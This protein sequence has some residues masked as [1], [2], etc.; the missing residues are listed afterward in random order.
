MPLFPD[1]KAFSASLSK[2]RFRLQLGINREGTQ[3]IWEARRRAELE[4]ANAEASFQRLLSEPKKYHG[5]VESLMVLITYTRRFSDTLTTLSA[6][7]NEFNVR[8]ELPGLET[9]AQQTEYTLSNLADAVGRGRLPQALP[10]L[11]ATLDAIHAHLKELYALRVAE[12]TANRGNTPTRK[13]ML[14]YALVSMLLDRIADQVTVMHLKLSELN[15]TAFGLSS[16][17]SALIGKDKH[18]E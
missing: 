16:S 2:L 8:D 14:D 3:A 12:V 10:P 15:S 18:N 13:A 5:S 17:K 11:N 1:L 4:N 9:F 6:Q 7:L